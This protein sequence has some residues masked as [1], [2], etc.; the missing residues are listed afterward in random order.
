[1][2]SLV[3]FLISSLM[4]PCYP[5]RV[6]TRVRFHFL[7]C[8][9]PWCVPICVPR[10]CPLATFRSAP[11]R[12]RRLCTSVDNLIFKPSSPDVAAVLD[13]ELSTLGHP[14]SDV[15]YNLLPYNMPAFP[16]SPVTGF[17]GVDTSA[18]GLPSGAFW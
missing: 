15:A 3:S 17:L 8:C 14:M 6:C 9:I 5:F 16:G 4:R 7:L 2:L 11:L 13:W 1:M 12:T 18:M 10:G